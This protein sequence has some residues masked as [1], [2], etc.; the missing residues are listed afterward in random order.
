MTLSWT[1]PLCES[2]WDKRNPDRVPSVIV[3]EHRD[4]E[5]CCDC[6]N[7]T[8]SGIYMRIDPSTVA[9]PAS[10]EES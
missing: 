9:Y 6:G 3:E 5:T 10:K 2:C 1:Q 7:A 8:R 4:Q